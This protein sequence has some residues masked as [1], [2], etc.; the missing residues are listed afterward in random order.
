MKNYLSFGG[1]VNSVA[2]YLLMEEMGIEFEAVFVN[3][4]GDWPETY[5]YIDYF[6]ATGRPV[7]ILLPTVRTRTKRVFHNIVDYF[8]YMNVLPTKNPKRRFCTARFKASVLDEYHKTPC[9]VFIGYAFDEA[10]RAV[11]SSSRGSEYRWPLIEHKITRQKC[12]DMI[13]AAGLEVPR[14]SGCYICPY[15]GR[16]EYQELRKKHPEL[17]CRAQKIEAS[18]NARITRDG[19]PWKPYFLAGNRPLL[20]IINDKQSALPGMEELEYPPCQC[21]L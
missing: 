11:I 6:I 4:G 12:V 2:L 5:E 9:F 1:G 18:Q 15:Q 17:F 16:R 10:H 8:E 13:K 20:E 7:T 21:G 3:H 14:K 19:R